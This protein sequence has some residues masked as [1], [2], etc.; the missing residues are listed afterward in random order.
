MKLSAHK[1]LQKG[2]TLIELLVVIGILGIL[3]AALV[4]TIDPFEQIQKGEDS[5]IKNMAVEFHTGLVRYYTTH[6]S[7]P[8]NDVNSDNT[9]CT[10]LGAGAIDALTLN[11]NGMI[12]CLEGSSYSLIDDGELKA[13]FTSNENDLAEVHVSWD[14]SN[15]SDVVICFAPVSKA[16][17]A[18]SETKYNDDGTDADPNVCPDADVADGTCYWC[19][20]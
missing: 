10:A 2:F 18:S 4:A 17:K 14:P 5:K 11:A 15:G 19:T 16:Q 6:G 9:D 7:F 12:D 1:T 13:A 20:R 8:W 3:A